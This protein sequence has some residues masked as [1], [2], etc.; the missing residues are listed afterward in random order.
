[1]LNLVNSELKAEL[2]ISYL[3]LVRI[4]GFVRDKAAVTLWSACDVSSSGSDV[5]GGF[6]KPS[7]RLKVCWK[8]SVRNCALLSQG[9]S[10]KVGKTP[11]F[12]LR[13]SWF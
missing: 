4:P 5:G 9:S 12:E 7:R 11:V 1:M 6:D 13:Y 10:S 8:W 3:H 2:H